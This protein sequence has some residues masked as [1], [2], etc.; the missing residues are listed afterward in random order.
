MKINLPFPGV[1]PPV[2]AVV[3]LS[4][5]LL[6]WPA[7]NAGE[8][9][10]TGSEASATPPVDSATSTRYGLFDLLDHRSSYEDGAFPEPLLV[11]D[12][13]LETDEFRL[14]WLRTWA[15]GQRGDIAK[16]ELEKGFGLWTL[17]LEVPFEQTRSDGQTLRGLGNVNLG[18]RH[19][20]Y[21]FVSDDGL[22]NSTF[23][24]AVEFGIPSGSQVSHNAELVPKI[25]NDLSLGRHFTIQSVLGIS[26][27][28]GGGAD[29]GLQTFE[30]GFVFGYSIP[31][32]DLP[33]PGI[34]QLVPI[35]ELQGETALNRE[36][37]GTNSLL[38]NLA[39]RV[40]FSPI[41][42]VQPRLGLGYVFPIS[43]GA[44][45]DVSSGFITSLVFEY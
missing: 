38:G 19:P 12:S 22:I 15:S 20:I 27:L 5:M 24:A 41:G 32:R 33:L 4:L 1:F 2:S 40:N 30:Y 31:H 23:G 9:A 26:T 17:E 6:M 45:Q 7:A 8:Q 10:G 25:F 39:I 37:A 21:Q 28:Y 35:F 13:V 3:N 14:D 34:R 11:D 43:Q 44:R 18:A 29:G 36:S 16:A 42:E